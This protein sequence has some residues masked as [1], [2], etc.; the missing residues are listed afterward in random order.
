MSKKQETNEAVKYTTDSLIKSK[1]LAKYQRDFVRVVLTK[2]EY[3]LEEAVEAIE[4]ELKK[5]V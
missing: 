2:P 4:G 3:T 1:A 5:E